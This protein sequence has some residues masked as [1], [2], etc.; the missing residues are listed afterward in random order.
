MI[1]EIIGFCIG[2][3]P[4][5]TFLILV[6]FHYK[7]EYNIDLSLWNFINIFIYKLAYI[8]FFIKYYEYKKAPQ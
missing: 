3:L 2:L 8:H 7:V 4:I 6:E 1:N 5:I